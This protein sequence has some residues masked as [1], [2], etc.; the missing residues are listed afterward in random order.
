MPWGIPPRFGGTPAVSK[1]CE[2]RTLRGFSL[3]SSADILT[4]DTSPSC[5]SKLSGMLRAYVIIAAVLLLGTH[6]SW[7]QLSPEIVWLPTAPVT[8]ELPD[9]FVSA[10]S[11]PE[12][13]PNAWSSPWCQD[14]FQPFN[15]I[16]WY[17]STP[18]FVAGQVQVEL[19]ADNLC[20]NH[21]S[22]KL[23]TQVR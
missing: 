13:L 21:T 1:R 14:A 8:I 11:S 3:S 4:V 7:A 20:S 22:L 16:P 23:L 10:A 18:A 9:S 19:L 6:V 5:P 17:L 15:P 2:W 12:P